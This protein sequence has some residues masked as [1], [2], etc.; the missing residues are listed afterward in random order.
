MGYTA[1]DELAS[2]GREEPILAAARRTTERVGQDLRE[3]VRR[4]T[5]IAKAP[6]GAGADWLEAR[7][8]MPGTLRESWRVG[9]VTIKGSA[10][11]MTIDVYTEDPIAPD[12]EWDTRPHVIRPRE[13]GTG[14]VLRYWDRSGGVV[15]ATVVHHP[16]TRGVHMM[17][18]ALVEIAASWWDIGVQEFRRFER[19]QLAGIR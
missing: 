7:H 18:T 15:F 4:H 6:P 10:G 14:G 12:V 16:G 2:F 17:A 5:P 11:R 1:S 13:K 19:E 8:R 9:E 3:R